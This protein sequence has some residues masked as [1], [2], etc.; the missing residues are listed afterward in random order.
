MHEV[1]MSSFMA[2]CNNGTSIPIYFVPFMRVHLG[3]TPITPGT[4]SSPPPV[5]TTARAPSQSSICYENPDS[6]TNPTQFLGNLA[7]FQWST[8]AEIVDH[9]DIRP[10][11]DTIP[12]KY[13]YIMRDSI[14][15]ELFTAGK[16]DGAGWFC[17]S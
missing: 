10:V 9:Y 8:T 15:A 3:D 7:S 5:Q 16:V 14:S 1:V 13:L 11:H 12:A 2:L 17:H 6:Q 4:P